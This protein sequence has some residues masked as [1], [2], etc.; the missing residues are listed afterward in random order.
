VAFKRRNIIITLALLAM[1]SQLIPINRS[2]PPVT[3]DL[4][5]TQELKDIFVRACYDCHS[6]ETIWPWYSR[7]APVSWLVAIDVYEGRGHLNFSTWGEYSIEKQD[8][9][10]KKIRE[11]VS[12]GEM[13]PFQYL[14]VHPQ[15][16]LSEQDKAVI[17]A[18]VAANPGQ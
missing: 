9:L 13:P 8:K 10:R 17:L 7:V 1:F 16:H 11:S 3:A 18:W 12:E 5:A 4:A 6:N 2:N 14:P 15:A